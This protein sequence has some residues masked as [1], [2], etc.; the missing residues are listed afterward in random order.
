M[1]KTKSRVYSAFMMRVVSDMERNTT[2][3]ADSKC[4]PNTDNRKMFFLLAVNVHE[5]M[6]QYMSYIS[7]YIFYML[8]FMVF[9][10]TF[11]NISFIS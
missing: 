10:V 8:R 11:N 1:M 6:D 5:N 4:R 3:S 2:C 7:F 9:N